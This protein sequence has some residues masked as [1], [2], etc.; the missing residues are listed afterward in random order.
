[1][2][3]IEELARS[4]GVS[5][6]LARVKP[7]V[8]RSARGRGRDRAAWAATTST[9]T[10]SAR[11]TQRSRNGSPTSPLRP[12]ARRGRRWPRR[13]APF[14]RRSL[15][16]RHAAASS[17]HITTR[18][19]GLAMASAI[20]AAPSSSRTASAFAVR[21]PSRWPFS[22]AVQHVGRRLAR[23]PATQ[24]GVLAHEDGVER[25]GRQPAVLAL[26]FVAPV[27]GNTDDADRPAVC[28]RR[29]MPQRTR[30]AGA[31]RRR[32]GSSRG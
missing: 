25:L 7:G 15:R 9:A 10:S 12:P 1:M 21:A 32:C 13:R 27:A 23:R 30:P 4:R 14:G 2:T 18:S 24:V 3:E 29:H 26:V 6:R 8:T 16:G 5:L 19:P 20:R 17:T 31:C 22:D 28:H 11:L